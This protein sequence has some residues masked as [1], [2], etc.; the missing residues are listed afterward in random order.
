MTD[1]NYTGYFITPI[2]TLNKPEWV[3][4]LNKYSDNFIKNSKKINILENKKLFKKNIGD[5]TKV[6]HS[7]SL[8]NVPS[9]QNIKNFVIDQCPLILNQMG[10]D[11]S[12]HKMVMTEMWV[13]EFGEKGGGSHEG[14]IHSNNHISGFYFLKC[15]D[16][17]S[18]PVFHDPRHTKVM[19]QLP[20]KNKNDITFINDLINYKPKPGTLILF[21]AFL[22]HSFIPDVGIDPFRFIHFNIQAINNNVL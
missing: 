22:E 13:Q 17:T 16:K 3:K 12:N 19:M 6:H 14:H 15:S 20:E 11:I 2:Y 8:I 5:L 9:F 18:F 7:T 1:F 21:P 10:Y 4:D